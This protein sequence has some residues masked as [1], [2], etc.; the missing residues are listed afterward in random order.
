MVN[1]YFHELVGGWA[2][3]LKNMKVKWDYC[4]QYMEK[5]QTTNQWTCHHMLNL[6]HLNKKSSSSSHVIMSA[7]ECLTPLFCRQANHLT[8][9]TMAKYG[10]F[11][12]GKWWFTSGRRGFAYF[13]ANLC[14]GFIV[15]YWCH[16]EWGF[17]VHFQAKYVNLC[18]HASHRIWKDF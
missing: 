1:N 12:Q 2:T 5:K 13:Q 17:I 15:T 14:W 10:Q 3:P 6:K 11:K 18:W 9:T 7:P 4:S 8:S 16:I